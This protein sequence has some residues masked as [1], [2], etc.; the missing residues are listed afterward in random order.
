MLTCLWQSI[1]SDDDTCPQFGCLRWVH[2]TGDY[3]AQFAT[4]TGVHSQ[5][6]LSLGLEVEG[7]EERSRDVDIFYH[8][9]VRQDSP[10][11]VAHP[12]DR[13]RATRLCV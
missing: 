5:C 12:G 3:T 2:R 6:I 11:S 10:Q 7:V 13:L 1:D 8:S 9:A 4:H